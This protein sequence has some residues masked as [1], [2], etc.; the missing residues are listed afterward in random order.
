MKFVEAFKIVIGTLFYWADK[1]L[2]GK[3]A[4]SKEYWQI[5]EMKK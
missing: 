5:K 2:F 4:Y 3:D 1:I